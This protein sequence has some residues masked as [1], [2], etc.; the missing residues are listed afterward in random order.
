MSTIGSI[1]FA[2]VQGYDNDHSTV[3]Y[4]LYTSLCLLGLFGIPLVPLCLELSVECV[5]PIPEAT[6]SGIILTISQIV[7]VVMIFI[8]PQEAATVKKD[9]Y[10]YN[11]VQTCVTEN[12]DSR[13]STSSDLQVLDFNNS[14]YAQTIIF[15]FVT[16]FFIIRFKCPYLRL[17]SEQQ[18]I[19]QNILGSH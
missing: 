8:Y 11:N 9:S 12:G 14:L 6:S 2:I 10:V 13:N 19:A 1:L 18:K 7:S 4:L 5:Y 17:K 16:I 15:F 3:K